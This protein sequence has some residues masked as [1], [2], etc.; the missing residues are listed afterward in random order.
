MWSVIGLFSTV[1]CGDLIIIVIV[2]ISYRNIS[3]HDHNKVVN[4]NNKHLP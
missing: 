3:D 1:Y 4:L 2:I